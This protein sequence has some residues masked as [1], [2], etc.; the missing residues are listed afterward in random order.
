MTIGESYHYFAQAF[1]YPWDREALLLSMEKIAGYLEKDDRRNPLS[2]FREF[3]ARNGLAAI[4]EEFVSTFD[5]TPECAPYVGYHLF[6]DNH[7]KGEYMI[8]VKGI[9]REHGFNAPENE[10][11]DHLSV[12]FGFL[13]HL[14][15]Q[16]ADD[17]RKEFIAAHMLEGVKK[18][19][20]V[21][22]KKP[23]VHWSDLITAA[24][25]V[26][27]ADCEEVASC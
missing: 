4:Q 6:G 2:G 12:L 19:H 7:K 26:C 8:R 20:E 11:P 21:A 10:L 15:F 1:T 9:Y 24:C 3:I 25:T 5:L 16:G 18:M 22:V 17:E 27:A 13:A 23:G 14:S